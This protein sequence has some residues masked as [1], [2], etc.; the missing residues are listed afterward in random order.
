MHALED[1]HKLILAKHAGDG[2]VV[3]LFLVAGFL[4]LELLNDPE[5]SVGLVLVVLLDELLTDAVV[6]ILSSL[7]SHGVGPVEDL[8]I[9]V[10]ALSEL[11]VEKIEVRIRLTGHL[12]HRLATLQLDAH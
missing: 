11:H 5:T 9:N 2:N 7:V 10:P 6:E 4:P 3:H 8:L 12:V 1:W